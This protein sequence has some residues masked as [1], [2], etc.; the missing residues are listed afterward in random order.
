MSPTRLYPLEL[1]SASVILDTLGEGALL[2]GPSG[3]ITWINRPLEYL[4]AINRDAYHGSDADQFVSRYLVPRIPDE[5]CREQIVR[6][7][8]DQ[9]DLSSL[10]CTIRTSNGTERRVLVSSTIMQDEP[11]QGMRLVW[12]HAEPLESE[13]HPDEERQKL[14]GQMGKQAEDL[15]TA[16]E[17]LTTTNEELEVANE[18]M[19]ARTEELQAL[20]DS[21]SEGVGAIDAEART[22]FVND[23]M[24]EMLGYTAKEMVGKPFAQFLPEEDRGRLAEERERRRAGVSEQLEYTFI[25]KDGSR[26]D[27]LLVTSPLYDGKGNYS[28]A[29]A[30]VMDIT[31]RKQMEEA[32]KENL[33]R[34]QQFFNNPLVGYALCE[35]ITDDHGNPADFVYLEIN[36]A[37]EDLTGLKREE[38]LNKRVTDILIPEEVAEIIQRYGEV[39]LTGESTTFLYPIPSLSKWFEIAVF[40]PQ[41]GQFIAFFTDITERKQAKEALCQEKER[42]G[43]ILS[44]L[45]TG[46]SLIEPDMTI[47]WVNQK[48]RDLFPEQEPV[49]QKC[50]RVYEGRSEPCE[51]CAARHVFATGEVT[52][53]ERYV[54]EH[55][56]WY[57]I[58]AQPVK[59][60]SGKVTE[61]LESFTDITERKRAESELLA[62]KEKLEIKIE[63]LNVLRRLSTKFIGGEDFNS[64]LQE[65]LEA[66]IT[67]TGADKGNIQLLNPSIGKLEIVA[68]QGFDL[69]FL[70]FFE[71]VDAGESAACGAAMERLERIIV[72]DVTISPIFRGS[73]ALDVLQREG[74]RAV[75]STP[76]VSRKGQ[77]LGM[78]STHFTKVHALSER[79]L[80]LID[81]LAR[82]AADIIERKQAEE[83]L[84]ESESR[85]RRRAAELQ[86]IME[87]VPATV[88]I[89]LDPECRTMFGSRR[90]YDLLRLPQGCNLSKSGPE[91]ERPAHFRVMQDGVEVPPEEMPVQKAAATG[92]PA[93][94]VEFDL[95]FDDGTMHRLLGNA[96]PLLDENGRPHGAVGAYI[97]IN[98]RKRV[99]EALQRRTDDLIRLNQEVEAARDEA[100]MYLDIMTHDVRNANNVSGMY[101]DLLVEL[102]AGDQW[103]YARKLRDAIQRSS[104][105]LRNVATIRRLQQESDRPMP[106]NLDAVI[107]EEVGNFPGASIRYDRRRV[108]VLADGLLPTVFNNLIGNAVKFGGPDMEIA[109]GIEEQGGEVLV[110]VE[111]T[112]PGVPDEMKGKLFH[113]FERGKARGSGEGL[114]LFICRTLVERYGGQIWVEDRVP[115]RPEKGSAFKFT[116]KKAAENS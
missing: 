43:S 42:M 99:E 46:Q 59:D 38:V 15:A 16:N 73:E 92:R 52:K 75:Q 107:R 71:R 11:F 67:L 54:P 61:A 115:G 105:I 84:R 108:D 109:I 82:Q 91:R 103:L 6:S 18:E 57:N 63:D 26:I 81:I 9:V 77:L 49:G 89:A 98:A 76:L 104:E 40:S 51:A 90:T 4:L 100:N 70:K 87:A 79:D 48:A 1:L 64:L 60:A 94:Q 10:A 102:L 83:A 112:G 20:L 96:V 19:H 30:G 65:M 66:A 55:G 113:R 72:E 25:R 74:V 8:R 45:D 32:L 31:E 50:Y 88:F 97:D 17:E 23:R 5:G 93:E 14:L 110:S 58:V 7:L 28:G 69:P 85:E 21:L 95:V 39:A 22:T 2:I 86:A 24:A 37:F 29:I 114:G 41:Q 34:Y 47:T 3:A 111:D 68:H 12:L 44:A 80:Q 36:Q 106:V 56:R 13:P 53:V 101:A 116:L 62:L 33:K 78:I 35:I 27:T